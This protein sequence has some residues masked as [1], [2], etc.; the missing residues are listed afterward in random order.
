MEE[1]GRG[2]LKGGQ[3]AGRSGANWKPALL[4][5]D[6]EDNTQVYVKRFAEIDKINEMDSQMG[7]GAFAVGP[8]RLGWMINMAQV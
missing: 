6:D 3:S 5:A 1:K 7:F 2:P 4:G 8:P